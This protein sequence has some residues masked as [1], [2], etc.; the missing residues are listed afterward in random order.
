MSHILLVEDEPSIQSLVTINLRRFGSEVVS[1]GSAA[2]A[3][4]S[5][6]HVLPQLVLLDW[7]LPD[8]AGIDLLRH[9]RSQSRTNALPILMLTARSEEDDIVRA[10][11]LGADDYLTKPF[12]IKELHARTQSLLRRARP[13]ATLAPVQ[14]GELSLDP[15]T[16]VV[17]AN[18]NSVKCSP[19]EFRLLHFFLKSPNIVHSRAKLL[20]AVWGDHVYIEE[21][22]VDVHIRRLRATLSQ[23]RVEDMLE[24]VRGTGYRLVSL[25]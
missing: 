24:T 5:V 2:Q 20:D 7:M 21:R 12:S 8:R 13:D 22:T 17:T 3:I 15:A 11:E 6:D 18:G 10:L 1:V 4:A 23:H 19:L 25:K 9:W 16:A 14:V